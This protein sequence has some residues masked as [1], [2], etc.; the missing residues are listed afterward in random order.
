MWTD[1]IADAMTQAA[2]QPPFDVAIE[3]VLTR[4]QRR[5]RRQRVGATAAVVAV[6]A[7]MVTGIV[8]VVPRAQSA[9]TA[10]PG[11]RAP[12]HDVLAQTKPITGEAAR[13]AFAAWGPTRGDLASNAGFL[14]EVR[15]EWANPTGD[16]AYHPLATGIGPVNILFAGNTPGG[17]AAVVEQDAKDADTGVF[18]GV[19]T[20]SP[21][22]SGLS[23]W[24][25]NDP[26]QSSVELT[27]NLGRFDLRQ[28]SFAVGSGR[29]II[30]LPTDATDTVTASLAEQISNRGQVA[31]SWQPVKIMDG[32]GVVNLPPT[33]NS[34]N[35]LFRV[36]HPG[37]GIDEGPVWINVGGVPQPANALG[38]WTQMNAV[39]GNSEGGIGP[40]TYTSWLKRYGAIGQPFGQS[41]WTVGGHL[42]NGDNL[43]IQQLWLFG[44]PA[45][46]VVLEQTP[47]I[48][49]PTVLSDT[50]TVPT[51][52]PLLAVALP[53]LGGWL[54]LAGPHS[55]VT[56][57][58]MV[59]SSTW[60]LP[61]RGI[62]GQNCGSPPASPCTNVYSRAAAVIPTLA[63]P[64]QIRLAVNGKT[65][66]VTESSNTAKS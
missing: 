20:Q 27:A 57:Y 55:T 62:A 10:G 51:A 31:R 13:A 23:L 2:E 53:A 50:V 40:N 3:P 60:T 66:T 63:S 6:V 64:I 19:M 42:P 28:V 56:G 25:P 65:R 59:G 22:G 34:W 32:V 58:R 47:T 7:A 9:Q 52:R 18:V 45:H 4:I 14:S 46:T 43:L 49:S 24:G 11:R 12:L 48:S 54:V 17:K 33:D 21:N 39:I 29:H 1:E 36:R 8:V 38:L 35:T 44:Q 30:V 26:T 37:R 5:Q 15:Q 41:G 16:E 61:P